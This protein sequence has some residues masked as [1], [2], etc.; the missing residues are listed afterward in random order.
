MG[1]NSERWP[2]SLA[3]FA[4]TSISSATQGNQCDF[5]SQQAASSL[6]TLGKVPLFITCMECLNILTTEL[7][8][9]QLYSD[10]D[11]LCWSV[12]FPVF[13]AGS[14]NLL[15]YAWQPQAATSTLRKTSPSVISTPRLGLPG[16]SCSHTP[17]CSVQGRLVLQAGAGTGAL[18]ECEFQQNKW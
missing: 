18:L 16:H 10:S 4:H 13:Q 5:Q 1:N 15:Q 17:R 6:A 3:L 2:H 11:M 12:R 14:P 7:S 9:H 8:I